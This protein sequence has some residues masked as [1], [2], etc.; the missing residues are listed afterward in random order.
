MPKSNSVRT[1]PLRATLCRG[2][3]LTALVL[4]GTALASIAVA[5]MPRQVD[6]TDTLD[7]TLLVFDDG[8]AGEPPAALQASL[9]AYP[10]PPVAITLN[11]MADPPAVPGQPRKVRYSGTVPPTVRGE[12]RL[13]LLDL[14]VA[15][16]M[17]GLARRT[18]AEPAPLPVV[19]E[20]T[21]ATTAVV[22]PPA[23]GAARAPQENPAA[24]SRLSFQDPVYFA[25]G[26]NGREYTQFQFSFKFRLF[27]P[28]TPQSRS[29][30][31]NLYIGYTQSALMDLA[32]DSYPIHDSLYNPS[33]YYYLPDTGL[34]AGW[35]TRT[36]FAAGYEHESNGEDEADSR[37]VE[38]LFVK[39]TFYLGDPA[40][41]HWTF[42][43]KL[44]YYAKKGDYNQD[45]EDYRGYG[46][47]RFTFGHPQS[48]ELAATLRTGTK[49]YTSGKLEATY[50][51]SQWV[52]S[53][54]GYLYLSY[55][56]GW[57]ETLIDY[58]Q[59]S[60]A[61]FRIGYSLWR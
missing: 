29:L 10:Q 51:L 14:D 31:D 7:V 5:P 4:P 19:S 3:L 20:A 44:Y 21:V 26:V 60:N 42:S 49:G 2:A 6:V 16:M 33:L 56:E 12:V 46:D 36:S 18:D 38:L 27:E 24:L 57:G 17:I 59:R 37:A 35:L 52:P 32:A 8:Q 34:N 9:T 48:L 30:L 22:D 54:M 50:P 53:M 13:E 45:I 47:Y 11:R 23:A 41:W 39:P 43:P 40:D 28:D 1:V 25:V 15:P 55:F 61:Q 58:N